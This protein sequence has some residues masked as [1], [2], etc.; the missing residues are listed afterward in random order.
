ML[1]DY[2]FPWDR[3]IGRFKFG[4]EPE[5]AKPLAQAL[6]QRV[7]DSAA[8]VGVDGLIPMP[9][10]PT[11]LRERG[12]NQ[13]WELARHL[14]RLLGIPARPDLLRRWRETPPQAGLSRAE[15]QRNLSHAFGTEADS[16]TTVNGQHWVLID[17]VLT[18]GATADSAARAL[19]DSGA[20]QVD[21]WVIART[22][23][24]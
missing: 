22:P 3:V 24:T 17:D 6:A 14:G 15:R 4:D 16:R 13:S 7:W 19:L 11:R 9:L 2:G 21:V 20:R 18:T 1:S 8:Q 5:L 12:Y 10:A 23:E